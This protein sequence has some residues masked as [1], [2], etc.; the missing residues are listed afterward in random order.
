[1][2]TE[3]KTPTHLH[4]PVA[5]EGSPQKAFSPEPLQVAERVQQGRQGPLVEGWRTHH[6]GPRPQKLR[7]NHAAVRGALAEQPHTDLGVE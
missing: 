5:P 3:T 2:P 7:R 1:M 6:K 4:R